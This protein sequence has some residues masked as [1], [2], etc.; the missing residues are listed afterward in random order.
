MTRRSDSERSDKSQFGD[1]Y[2][3]GV[4]ASIIEEKSF[5][6][7]FTNESTKVF[8]IEA[9]HRFKIKKVIYSEEDQVVK[10]CEVINFKDQEEYNDLDHSDKDRVALIEETRDHSLKML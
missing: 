4:M 3:Y 5:F 6:S 2:S 8:L 10:V 7:T 9:E 1:H